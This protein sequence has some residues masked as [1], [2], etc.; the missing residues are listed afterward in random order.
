MLSRACSALLWLGELRKKK[1]EK[2]KDV[3]VTGFNVG[4]PDIHPAIFQLNTPK[5]QDSRGLSPCG[6][7]P[8]NR[9]PTCKALDVRPP[10]SARKDAMS[11]N[12]PFRA[13]NGDKKTCERV[14]VL[15]NSVRKQWTVVT[16][17]IVGLK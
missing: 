10:D 3:P 8:L 5:P 16:I 14:R 15:S 13:Y 17:F 1:K 9:A 12:P 2:K 7:Y 6:Q 4:G 11:C